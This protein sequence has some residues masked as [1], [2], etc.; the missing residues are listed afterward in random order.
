MQNQAPPE[1]LVR[2]NNFRTRSAHPLSI[3]PFEEARA[4]LPEPVLPGKPEWIEMYWR[5]W[6]VAWSNLQRA[7]PQRGFIA[8]HIDPAINGCTALWDASFTTQYGVYGRRAT[9]LMGTLDNFYAHQH[10]DGFICRA[11][12]LEDG[13]DLYSAYSPTSAGPS[14][15]SWAEWSHYRATGDEVRLADVFWPLLANHRWLRRNRSWRDGSYWTTGHSSGM[16]DQLRVPDGEFQH[17]HWVWVDATMQASLDCFLL[18]KMARLLDEPELAVELD[19][20]RQRLISLINERLWSE[21]SQ[22]YLDR[23]PAGAFS[24]TKSIGA[25]WGLLDPALVE[26]RRLEG[27]LR[28]LRDAAAFNTP[29]RVPS[30]S[31]DSPGYDGDTGNGWRGA[32]SPAA[33]Y[34]LIKGL[35]A[36]GQPQLAHAISL[37]H[38]QH[39]ADVFVRTDTFWENYAPEVAAPG[40]PARAHAVGAAGVAPIALL[41]EDVLGLSIDW[42]LRRVVWDRRLE[43][44]VYGVN[45]YPLGLNGHCDLLVDGD[46]LHVRSTTAFTL[47]VQTPPSGSL[48]IPI[49]AGETAVELS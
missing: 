27:F 28:H 37:N 12:N 1:P 44:D 19:G 36:V 11:L 38:L 41:L 24:P 42:P 48:Q 25:Y 43:A 5:A 46:T 4:R 2:R 14:I 31:K 17:Q 8:N 35:R 21:E 26:G 3:P 34:M 45:N 10:D 49:S 6:E 15:L 9:G 33:N 20:E 7:R 13:R 18:E 29:H 39:V 22:F 32:V 47:V 23:G 16:P 30:Q 40:V